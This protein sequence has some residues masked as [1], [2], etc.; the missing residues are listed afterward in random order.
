MGPYAALKLLDALK[1]RTKLDSPSPLTLDISCNYFL[2][3]DRPDLFTNAAVTVHSKYRFYETII[4]LMPGFCDAQPQEDKSFTSLGLRIHIASKTLLGKVEELKLKHAQDLNGDD[5]KKVA[6]EGIVKAAEA[7]L[8]SFQNEIK[9]LCL[10]LEMEIAR[11]KKEKEELK[12]KAVG[13]ARHS[14]SLLDASM[15]EAERMLIALQ[16]E[17]DGA[18]EEQI[19]TDGQKPEAPKV[20]PDLSTIRKSLTQFYVSRIQKALEKWVLVSVCHVSYRLRCSHFLLFSDAGARASVSSTSPQPSSLKPAPTV[21]VR[22]PNYSNPWRKTP[23]SSSWR[24]LILT[25]TLT[26]LLSRISSSVAPHSSPL[27]S[28]PMISKSP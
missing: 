5:A 26:C 10:V 17:T 21:R 20:E 6:A 14:E 25:S 16:R 27:F 12:K 22:S 3:L 18:E 13:D 9:D 7:E 24:C 2:I 19:K 4:S 8:V 11:L 15:K 28:E 23:S 1:K